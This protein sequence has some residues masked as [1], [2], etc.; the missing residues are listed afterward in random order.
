MKS[1]GKIPALLWVSKG[2]FGSEEVLIGACFGEFHR[3]GQG[4]NQYTE[5]SV[6]RTATPT[7][8]APSERKPHVQDPVQDPPPEATPADIAIVGLACRMP[9][10][11]NAAEFWENLETGKNCVTEIPDERWDLWSAGYTPHDEEIIKHARHGALVDDIDAFDAAFFGI[12]PV[13]AQH[14]D[15]QQR[16]LM[17]LTWSCIEDAGYDPKSLSGTNTGV[18]VGWSNGDY[19]TLWGATRAAG[20]AYCGPGFSAAM[21]PNRVSH[22]FGFS[23][24][25]VP[26]NTA[27]SSSLVALHQ[28]VRAINAGECEMAFVG[29]VNFHSQ[30]LCYVW[31]DTA[32]MLSADGEC[33]TFDETANGYVRGEGCGVIML[34]RLS[35][36][37][38]D[39][40]R[41]L[42]VIKGS[43]V[44]HGA[45]A[46]TLTSPNPRAQARVVA[47]AIEQS[48]VSP[49][50]IGY[51]EAHGT[52]TPLG[53][54]IEIHGLK[55]AFSRMYKARGLSVSDTPTCAIGAVKTY[56]GHLE[57]AAGIAG[58]IHVLLSM[59]HRRLHGLNHFKT[60]NSRIKLEQSP[61]SMLDS[62]RSWERLTDAKGEPV[63]LR[64]GVS[65]F[66]FGG[67]NAHVILEED[68]RSASP[69]SACK[70]G[71]ELLLI[72]G[73][74]SDAL[75][76]SAT[77]IKGYLSG[78]GAEEDLAS[79]AHTLQ[80]GRA[81][82]AERLALLVTSSADAV[83]KL[84]N[85]LGAGEPPPMSWSGTATGGAEVADPQSTLDKWCSD[86]HLQQLA[87]AWVSG[88]TVDWE[89]LARDQKPH[90]LALPSYPFARRRHW[91]DR[92][93][94]APTTSAEEMIVVATNR[95]LNIE[96]FEAMWVQEVVEV[97]FDLDLPLV[98]LESITVISLSMRIEKDFGLKID[99]EMILATHDTPRKIIDFAEQA[100][101]SSS[102]IHRVPIGG[103]EPVHSFEDL[104][105]ETGVFDMCRPERWY[106]PRAKLTL[107]IIFMITNMRHG[108]SLTSLAINA[109]PR[110]YAPQG[111]YLLPFTNLAER[112]EALKKQML[113][114]D[115]GLVLTVQDLW[116]TDRA[117]AE[118]LVA[119][120]ETLRLPIHEVYRA[121][122]EKCAPRILVDR[123]TSYALDRAILERAERLFDSAKYLHLIRH[124]YSVLRSG[125]TLLAKTAFLRRLITKEEYDSG[126][127][128]QHI[129]NLVDKMWS[130]THINALQFGN[131]ID[132]KRYQQLRFEELLSDPQPTLEAVCKFAG[133]PFDDIML[134]PYDVEDNIALHGMKGRSGIAS[135]DPNLM[136]HSQIG[137]SGSQSARQKPPPLP[138]SAATRLFAKQLSYDVSGDADTQPRTPDLALPLITDCEG[139]GIVAVPGTGGNLLPFKSLLTGLGRPAT[140]L[141][142]V[143]YAPYSTVADLGSFFAERA[144]INNGDALVGYSSGA[145]IVWEMAAALIRQGKSISTLVLIDRDPADPQGA[146]NVAN[147]DANLNNTRGFFDLSDPNP[148]AVLALMVLAQTHFGVAGERLEDLS[149]ALSPAARGNARPIQAFLKFFSALHIQEQDIASFVAL[150]VR[151]RRLMFDYKPSAINV[152][153]IRKVLIQARSKEDV[154]DDLG[155]ERHYIE[156]CDHFTILNKPE[157]KEILHDVLAK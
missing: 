8:G 118:D 151:T 100:A 21:L 71:E 91:L 64:A 110:L 93:P 92:I 147:I 121:I 87:K 86:G 98:D 56:I 140:G 130:T 59:K 136:K 27:C 18:F 6:C 135:T 41:V 68:V 46:P 4:H 128:N 84:R 28:A 37:V 76:E 19:Q 82:M 88:A 77:L 53:D 112:A 75:R 26:V 55:R 139:Q 134:R 78:V 54:P 103:E 122:Q 83:A 101:A 39:G 138:V 157:L 126:A 34:K 155:L 143:D 96:S 32:G 111:L 10:A 17:E 35:Q 9:H 70:G 23:G 38:D 149:E 142:M 114:L 1:R 94:L 113:F 79:V 117:G 132:P 90:R 154:S 61:F 109:N 74:T 89:W 124:P 141:Q 106:F 116:K 115:E 45:K 57:G 97:D 52:G 42:G 63:P 2:P 123:G 144:P 13:E 66:G 5:R 15:P 58:V 99:Q 22:F 150:F 25:S 43:A 62:S 14:M 148:P 31:F 133:V 146:I 29:G 95:V 47:E 85:W 145:F 33:R 120:W 44:H 48:G 119:E 105:V 24:P 3:G 125:T 36:A 108:S 131:T 60:L 16:M 72:S 153:N 80:L 30:P 7:D 152:P 67:A 81:P 104:E 127:K 51:I 73:R 50:T 40:D 65:S 129:H 137:G 12:S 69:S 107:P 49:D 20:G 11:R 102:P 156:D